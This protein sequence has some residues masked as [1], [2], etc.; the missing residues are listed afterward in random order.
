M[1]IEIYEYFSGIS[2]RLLSHIKYPIKW[3]AILIQYLSVSGIWIHLSLT[4]TRSS[5]PSL[6]V[7]IHI[8]PHSTS[9][10][11]SQWHFSPT[12]TMTAKT[13]YIYKFSNEYQPTM[14]T[15][16]VHAFHYYF[17]SSVHLCLEWFNDF[18]HSINT[19]NNNN[20]GMRWIFSLTLLVMHLKWSKFNRKSEKNTFHYNDNIGGEVE[21][22]ENSRSS[23]PPTFPFIRFQFWTWQ[24]MNTIKHN[25]SIFLSAIRSLIEE[26]KRCNTMWDFGILHLCRHRLLFLL[27]FFS[28][29]S[30]LCQSIHTHTHTQ[31][32]S[33][34]FSLLDVVD[35]SHR[36]W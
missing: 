26:M 3:K 36:Q 8:R 14:T 2:F 15:G 32:D 12:K 4:L 7:S 6:C 18:I 23:P 20:N 17:I 31:H 33:H 28:S 13:T 10:P 9:I 11:L 34:R 1:E 27:F 24:I 21:E 35:R 29:P 19:S 25:H 30:N 22:G 16:M 5:S